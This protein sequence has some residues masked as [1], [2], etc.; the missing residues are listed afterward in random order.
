MK[1]FSCGCVAL[2]ADNRNRI[3]PCVTHQGPGAPA[4]TAKMQNSR[5]YRMGQKSK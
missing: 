1:R 3:V 5:L 2:K 4:G